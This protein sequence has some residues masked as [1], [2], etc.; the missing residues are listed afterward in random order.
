[1]KLIYKLGGEQFD[2]IIQGPKGPTSANIF[3]SVVYCEYLRDCSNI[4]T[5]NLMARTTSLSCLKLSEYIK[6]GYVRSQ[7]NT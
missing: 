6:F 2:V 4:F 1:M 7:L 3:I 5:I